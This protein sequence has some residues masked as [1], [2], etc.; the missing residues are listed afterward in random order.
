MFV[1][2]PGAATARVLA[3]RDALTGALV[4]LLENAMQN[5]PPGAHISLSSELES[6]Q[7][8]LRVKDTGPGIEPVMLERLF[9]PFF[10]TRLDGTGLGLAIVRSVAQAHG[11]E[12][13]VQSTLGLGSL[14]TLCLPC[15]KVE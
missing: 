10:T 14:F 3:S 4:N 6:E 9:E 15:I 5:C 2:E 7:V 13:Q 12:V 8:L 1:V 11:G